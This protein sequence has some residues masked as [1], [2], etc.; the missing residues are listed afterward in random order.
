MRRD[1]RKL[2]V[3]PLADE[4]VLE[5]YRATAVFPSEERYGLQS[6]LRRAA[7]RVVSTLVEGCARRTTKDY[8]HFVNMSL[9]SASEVRY[10]L[11]VAGRLGFM[12]S[13]VSK[14]LYDRCDEPVRG[15]Q[16]LMSSLE[17]EA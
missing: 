3:F 17:N 13:S 1:H 6:Q 15:L 4:L 8:L 7:V 12:E 9:A 11:T 2:K 5:I 16:R 10:E 14:R